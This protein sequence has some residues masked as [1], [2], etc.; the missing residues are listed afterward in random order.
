MASLHDFTAKTIDG[1]QLPL[2]Q[3]EGKVLLVVNVASKCGLTPQYTAL[4]KVYRE[5]KED[6]FEVLGF[7]CNDFAGQEPGSE[8]EIKTFC[9]TNYDVT[10]PLF[11]KVKV[12]GEQKSEV[13]EYLTTQD[14]KPEGAGDVAWNFAKWVIGKDGQIVGRFGP[15]TAPDAPELTSVIEDALEA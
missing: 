12:L 10:F 8:S 2:K 13:F 15:R 11:A 7:P 1:T 3:Y 9:S 6:G 5:Y 4:E 14:T